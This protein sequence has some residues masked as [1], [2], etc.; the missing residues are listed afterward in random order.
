LL[1]V[2]RCFFGFRLF[3]QFGH[4]RRKLIVHHPRH[5]QAIA[6]DLPIQLLAPLAHDSRRVC[7]S[8][9]PH[10]AKTE[11]MLLFINV[12]K[13][14]PSS[15]CPSATRRKIRNPRERSG[16]CCVDTVLPVSPQTRP[17]AKAHQRL[18]APVFPQMRWGPF[19]SGSSLTFAGSPW[20]K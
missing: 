14:M 2:E 12:T 13:M 20:R 15:P 17:G 5:D 8:W 4:P 9:L 16:F 10:L 11:A 6:R 7:A 18:A 19:Y 1:A 3:D